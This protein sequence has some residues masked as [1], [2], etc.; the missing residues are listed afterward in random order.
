MS[1]WFETWFETSEYLEIYSHRNEEEAEKLSNLISSQL[2]GEGNKSVL[3]L[4][5]GAGRHSL[6]FAKKGFSVTGIDLSAN[7]LDHARHR[8]AAENLKVNFI[9]SDIRNLDYFNSFDIIVNLFTSFGYF[10]SDEQN[11]SILR[12]INNALKP[13]GWFIIDFFNAD[14]LRNNLVPQSYRKYENYA[15]EQRRSISQNR[16]IKEI[17]ITDAQNVRRYF[18]SVRLYTPDELTSALESEGLT[19]KKIFGDYSG[20]PLTKTS[21]RLIIFA[22]KS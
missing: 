10:E 3:D 5:C 13:E 19:V 22:Q 1:E 16:V 6:L 18:E 4:C 2:P 7:L 20:N 11:F 9:R 21:E 15:I 14:Y 12:A 8:A 17:K